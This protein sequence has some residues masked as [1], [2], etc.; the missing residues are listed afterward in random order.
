MA[1]SP[2]PKA[3]LGRAKPIGK[4]GEPAQTSEADSNRYLILFGSCQTTFCFLVFSL[5]L[6]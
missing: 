3:A 5:H 6:E 4:I 2:Q 1:E